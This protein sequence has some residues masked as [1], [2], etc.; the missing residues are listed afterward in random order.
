MGLYLCEI[1]AV[2]PEGDAFGVVG[3]FALGLEPQGIADWR[4]TQ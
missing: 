2:R 3:R 4:I 1:A